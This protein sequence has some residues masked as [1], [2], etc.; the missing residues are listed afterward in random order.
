[1]DRPRGHND[2][3]HASDALGSLSRTLTRAMEGGNIRF[4]KVAATAS[5]LPML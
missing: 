2:I 1:M 5:F 4:R 3:H